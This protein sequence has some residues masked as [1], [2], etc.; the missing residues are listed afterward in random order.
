MSPEQ[1]TRFYDV[2]IA[3]RC[4]AI[5]HRHYTAKHVDRLAKEGVVE[6]V[7]Q[8]RKIARWTREQ[9]WENKRGAMQLLSGNSSKPGPRQDVQKMPQPCTAMGSQVA[10]HN[11]GRIE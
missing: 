5:D 11:D 3:H 8:H 9:H 2:S 6:W 1:A 7:G 10:M 4:T